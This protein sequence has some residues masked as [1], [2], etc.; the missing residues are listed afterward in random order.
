MC[1]LT[2]APSI[3]ITHFLTLVTS[4]FDQSKQVYGKEML[5]NMAAPI[6]KLYIELEFRE[7]TD[8]LELKVN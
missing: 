8:L 5:S 4:C 3:E 6:Y 2:I 1:G 7:K